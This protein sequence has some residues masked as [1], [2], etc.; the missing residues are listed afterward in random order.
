[1]TSKEGAITKTQRKKR[2]GRCRICHNV[3]RLTKEHVPPKSAFNDRSYREYYASKSSE[4]ERIKWEAR[5]VNRKGIF[6]FTLCEQCNNRTGELYGA[7]Y[8]KFVQAFRAVATPQRVRRIVE[9]RVE[10]FFPVRVIKQAVS[11]MLSTSDARAFNGYERFASPFIPS[12]TALPPSFSVRAKDVQRIREVYRGL[13]EFVLDKTAKGFPAGVRLYAYAV[14]NEG[15]A[16]RTGIGIQ[17]RLSTQRA[18][19]VVVAGLWPI[20]WVLLLNGDPLDDEVADFTDWSVLDFKKKKTINVQIPCQ[21]SVGRYPLDF[22]SPEEFQKGRFINLMQFEGFRPTALADDEQ[23]FRGAVSFARV[24][25]RWTREGYLMTEFRSGT[26]YEAYGQYGWCEGL[27][28]DQAR[29]F[30]R[31]QLNQN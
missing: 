29:E 6:L 15:A 5:D 17:A 25:G 18:H 26:Y 7:D 10:S 4:A 1:M 9:A 27:N 8:L 30:V 23:R 3:G 24:R 21:W 11:M 14:A 12:D 16:I 2:Y 20:H 19:W 13:G 22:R 31:A 28:R